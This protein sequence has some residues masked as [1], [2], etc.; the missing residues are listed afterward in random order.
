MTSTTGE[1]SSS[2][3]IQNPDMRAL[4][5]FITAQDATQ[6]DNVD[7]SMVI[8]DLTHSNL[9]QRHI[10]IRFFKHDFLETLRKRIHQKTGTAPQFQHLQVK[11]GDRVL[12]EIPPETSDALKLGYFG[13]LYHGLTVHCIDTNP[14]SESR[15][16]GYEDT[17]LVQKYV[18]DDETY[19]KRQNTLHSW[20]QEKKE[21]NP[22]FTLSKHMYE[23]QQL[24]EARKR[25]KQGLSL[26]QG[27]VID[28]RGEVVRDEADDPE[29]VS[30]N[31]STE[32]I[33]V[34]SNIEVGQ[35]CQIEPGQRR[36]KVAWKGQLATSSSAATGTSTTMKQ[37]YVGVLLDEPSGHNDGTFENQRFFEA[38]PR[39]GIFVRPHNLEVGDF[40]ERDLWDDSE[41]EL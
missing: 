25:H 14:Y 38:P 27:Y 22:N 37:N 15:K 4:R 6:F 10:E 18:M 11:E 34:L 40:P 19:Q 31:I 29:P 16:G 12:V 23:H 26:P 35:R 24:V 33:A 39:H 20:I 7:E 2:P 28:S 8:I 17:S 30:N 41:D 1:S 36:G 5:N 9:I 32:D 3:G 13:I 21:E